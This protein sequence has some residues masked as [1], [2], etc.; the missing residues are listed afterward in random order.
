MC[1]PSVKVGDPIASVTINFLLVFFNSG[2]TLFSESKVILV[3]EILSLFEV[4][5]LDALLISK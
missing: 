2:L 3:L 5:L 1:I 4:L